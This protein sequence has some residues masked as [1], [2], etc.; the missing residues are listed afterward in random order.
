MIEFLAIWTFLS[1]LLGLL[2]AQ[3]MKDDDE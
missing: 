2:I 3:A 1:I